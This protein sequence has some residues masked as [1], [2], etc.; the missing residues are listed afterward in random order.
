MKKL[1]IKL[2]KEYLS[3]VIPGIAGGLIVAIIID[4]RMEGLYGTF[5][6]LIT[7]PATAIFL[8]IG[9]IAYV[10]FIHIDKIDKRIGKK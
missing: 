6:Y 7:L 4:P 5:K 1:L 8:V 3:F 10:Y 2:F 9:F